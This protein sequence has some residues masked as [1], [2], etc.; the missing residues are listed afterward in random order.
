VISPAGAPSRRINSPPCA[1]GVSGDVATKLR[2][3]R[4]GGLALAADQRVAPDEIALV[5]LH[6]E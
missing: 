4:A 3:R 1:I 6:G 5:E 2:S